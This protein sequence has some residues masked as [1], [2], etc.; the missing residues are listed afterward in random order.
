MRGPLRSV[1]TGRRAGGIW[2]RSQ[3]DRDRYAEAIPALRKLV[4]FAP[5]LGSAWAFLGLSEFETHDYDSSLTDLEKAHSIGV[6]DD[7]E[8]ARVSGY[9]LAL[10]LNRHGDFERAARCCSRFPVRANCLR[11]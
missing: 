4:Q 2:E 1:L 5:N 3:Y 10:L 11:K 9:H 8:L 6:A 7:Q